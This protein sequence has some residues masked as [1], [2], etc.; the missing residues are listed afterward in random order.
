MLRNVTNLGAW[1]ARQAQIV[2]MNNDI[3]LNSEDAWLYAL[4]PLLVLVCTYIHY[5]PTLTGDDTLVRTV[6]DAAPWLVMIHSYQ[7]RGTLQWY[8]LTNVALW[9]VMV[10]SYNTALWLVMAH[11]NE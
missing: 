2:A 10:H 9:L 7:W 1:H 4:T 6:T 3:V 8:F 5:T 11:S